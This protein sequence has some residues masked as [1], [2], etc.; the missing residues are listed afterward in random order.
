[1]LLLTKDYVGSLCPPFLTVLGKPYFDLALAIYRAGSFDD[2]VD[3]LVAKLPMM[4][5]ADEAV[6]MGSS[7]LKGFC[8][9]SN[10]GPIARLLGEKLDLVNA[11]LP[12]NPIVQRVDF[13]KPGDLGFAMSD[14]VSPEDY[15]NSK[16]V[17]EIFGDKAMND[18]LFGVLVHGQ[19]R[20]AYLNCYISTGH[21]GYQARERFD[22]ILLTARG[23]LDRLEAYMVEQSVRQRVFAASSKTPLAIFIIN[24]R[25]EVCPLNHA[26]VNIAESWWE[27][28]EAVRLLRPAQVEELDRLIDDTWT[29]PVTARWLE[30]KL[31]LGG[32]EISV[33]ALAKLNGEVVLMFPV[34]GGEDSAEEA[35]SI[36]TRRQREIME[37]I[38]EGKTSGEAAIILGISP[39]TVE[40]H[41][42][43]VFQRLGV[44]NRIAAMRRYLDMKRGL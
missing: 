25:A 11:L 27:A 40:K 29:N 14:H 5:G 30:M 6:V 41:L 13:N 37:W 28:D 38:A 15:R 26:A 17:R 18:V 22:A 1:V 44:E 43:A 39:R 23:V 20:T 3:L 7:P 10:H 21:F 9:V 4:I 42:E 12:V 19:R 34:P 16:F 8:S 33:H 31:D 24:T 32:G 2:I 35:L 36:L